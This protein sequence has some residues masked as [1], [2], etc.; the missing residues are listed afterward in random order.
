MSKLNLTIAKTHE[1]SNRV[2]GMQLTAGNF[3]AISLSAT[4]MTLGFIYLVHP[5]GFQIALISVIGVALAI[6]IER[7]TLGGLIAVR[8]SN[9]KIFALTEEHDMRLIEEEREET[10]RERRILDRR[11]D[12]LKSDRMVSIPVSGIGM[13]LS[14]V[15]G[16][17]FWHNIFEPL[18]NPWLVFP[19]SFACAAVIGL[20]FVYSELYKT[21]MDK[22]LDEIIQ[23]HHLKDT[24]VRHEEKNQQLD[25]MVEAYDGLRNDEEKREPAQQIV[26]ETLIKRLTDF[27]S[28]IE[29][30]SEQNPVGGERSNEPNEQMLALT[31]QLNALSE[32]M[33]LLAER[34]NEQPQPVQ[35]TEA[36]EEQPQIEAPAQVP[37]IEAPRSQRKPTGRTRFYECR[38]ELM[39]LRTNDPTM[40]NQAI[41]DHFGIAKSTANTWLDRLAKEAA[42]SEPVE[43]EAAEETQVDDVA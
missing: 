17:L 40:S 36:V 11:V 32:Q 43:Q 15:I 29:Q 18:G 33:A 2:V 39:Q 24:A 26:E 30:A 3:V 27:A 9:E 20:T 34:S 5:A 14:T 31:D 7:L 16:D 42:A 6:L 23:D 1:L 22:S 8:V 21:L 13:L 38:D 25:L 41:A 4:Q 12:K 37:Q 19:M 28:G 35:I 10:E